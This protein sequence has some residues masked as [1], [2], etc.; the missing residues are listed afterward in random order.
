MVRLDQ[1]ENKAIG[2][3]VFNS[4][5]HIKHFENYQKTIKKQILKQEKKYRIIWDKIWFQ[6]SG[7]MG[8]KP[9]QLV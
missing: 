2:D 9:N 4:V 8:E 3:F 7:G 5:D 1:D 6:D